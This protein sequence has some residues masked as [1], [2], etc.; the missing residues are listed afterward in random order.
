[1]A[2][3]L[4]AW[5]VTWNDGTADHYGVIVNNGGD[6]ATVF[7]EVEIETRGNARASTTA[8]DRLITF[9]TLPPGAYIVESP[10]KNSH[11]KAVWSRKQPVSSLD[12]YSP[13]L[14]A[15][16]WSIERIAFTD[17]TGARWVWTPKGSFAELA[18][19]E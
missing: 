17:S 1:M 11:S 19:S 2:S 3:Q 5:W 13:L 4:Q 10:P 12:G 14:D 18:R 6:G 16:A 9:E 7:R 8:P 15:R